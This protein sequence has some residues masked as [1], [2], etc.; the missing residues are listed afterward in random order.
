MGAIAL[1]GEHGGA[2]RVPTPC[3]GV[4]GGEGGGGG[5]WFSSVGSQTACLR[6]LNLTSVGRAQKPEVGKRRTFL[7]PARP[8]D[9]LILPDVCCPLCL[10]ETTAPLHSWGGEGFPRP[11]GCQPLP[12][13]FFHPTP[14][15]GAQGRMEGERG[16]WAVSSLQIQPRWPLCAP[17]GKGTVH[18]YQHQDQQHPKASRAQRLPIAGSSCLDHFFSLVCLLPSFPSVHEGGPRAVGEPV[19]G[20][21]APT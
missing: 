14:H 4:S 2:W 9:S 15:G 16:A 10:A 12:A 21:P 5:D 18:A 3:V 19:V 7:S 13:H 17:V 8:P 1:R 6:L 20:E 11:L